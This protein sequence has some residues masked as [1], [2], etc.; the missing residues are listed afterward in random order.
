VAVLIAVTAAGT[1]GRLLT[2]AAGNL[3]RTNVVID[4][5]PLYEVHPNRVAAGERR[6]G[7]LVAHGFAGSAKLMAQFGDTLA[8]Q[9]YVVVL[10]DFS[11]HG[12]NTRPLPDDKAG[13]GASG[14]ALQHD[15][16]V[17]MTHLRGLREV[18]PAR[19]ALVGH[20]MGAT[21]VTRYAVAH[22]EVTAT[23]AI[24]LPNSDFV[25]PDRPARWLLLV[26][27]AEFTGFRATAQRAVANGARPGD[28]PGARS[29]RPA[30]SAVVVPGVEHI[31]ILYAPRTHRET[32]SWLNDSFGMP[33][34]GSL[35][36]PTRRPTATVLL[37]LAFLVGLYPLAQLLLGNG[38]GR[39]PRVVVAQTGRSAAVAGV[40]AVAATAVAPVAPTTRLPLA[41]GGFLVGFTLT[42]GL[43]MLGYRQW[44][45]RWRGSAAV[46][47]T[48]ADVGPTTANLGPGRLRLA[49]A[50]PVLI[51]YAGAAIAV[52]LHLGLTQ[53][54]PVG[55]RWWLLLF[56]WA[57]FAVLTYAAETVSG[58]NSFAVLAVFG[59]MVIALS[60]AAVVG[61]ASS[62]LLLVI[63]LLAV[64]LLCQTGWNA[65]L[66][67]FS[68]PIWLL[69]G[70]GSVL[71]AWPLAIALPIT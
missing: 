39:W 3:S 28:G 56:V 20:S 6:P 48:T 18:D 29:S 68:A 54:L 55:A 46:A 27:A 17:A 57:G 59:V 35:P 31:S 8:S 52:P 62:F 21:A 61:P 47:T 37:L 32:V 36:A 2:A 34:T 10:L 26:G 65:V 70:I 42:A 45:S 41:I 14:T 25:P 23:V 51:G 22:P 9:G 24:S 16:D 15:L 13:S 43:T 50:T 66:H 40:S 63:P 12:A 5:V 60:A 58:G 19:V 30:R 38:P 53:A 1:G 67:R 4:G 64:L 49:L 33:L 7:V 69:S 71:V 44:R 11:G